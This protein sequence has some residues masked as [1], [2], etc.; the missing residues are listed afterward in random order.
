M[1]FENKEIKLFRKFLSECG[2]EYI[3]S[4]SS[5][6]ENFEFSYF[7]NYILDDK[8][9]VVGLRIRNTIKNIP[10]IISEFKHLKVLDIE[11]NK[12]KNIDAIKSL[13]Q[14]THLYISKN[15]I[16][17]I[18]ILSHL[19]NL[20]YLYAENNPI[21]DIASIGELKELKGVFLYYT[22]LDLTSTLKLKKLKKLEYLYLTSYSGYHD[23]KNKK[24]RE[25][26]NQLKY[27]NAVRNETNFDLAIVKLI[28]LENDR[29]YNNLTLSE[30]N[31][32]NKND[33]IKKGYVLDNNKNII[34]CH[35]NRNNK[36]VTELKHLKTFRTEN[37]GKFLNKLSHI[38]ELFITHPIN[39]DYTYLTFFSELKK[40]KKIKFSARKF[41]LS[42]NA[43]IDLSFLINLK[44]LE[45]LSFDGRNEIL[46][47]L[48]IISSLKSLKSL[49]IKNAKLTDISKLKTLLN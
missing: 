49:T 28:E 25:E 29:A 15:N 17:D 11:N 44:Q 31:E 30:F 26:N 43:N 46:I 22:Q 38:E 33:P 18:S 8:K 37:T 13:T 23:D 27:L 1:I 40:L 12:I 20:Q 2:I 16:E 47:D 24:G 35:F 34:A 21:K 32:F 39:T 19:N 41:S 7:N 36:L 5:F 42:S 10:D 48:D 9:N 14:L 4:Y 6:K 3:K 45:N